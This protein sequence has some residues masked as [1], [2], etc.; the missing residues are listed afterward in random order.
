MEST[1]EQTPI[2]IQEEQEKQDVQEKQEEIVPYEFTQDYLTEQVKN[3][4]PNERDLFIKN[5]KVGDYQRLV[6]GAPLEM[7]ERELENW[8]KLEDYIS[9]NNLDPLPEYY[10]DNQRIGFRILQGTGWKTDVAYTA[11][12]EHWKWRQ[13]TFPLD[14]NKFRDILDSGAV[15]CIGRA[16]EGLQPIIIINVKRFCA[17]N[18][19]IEEQ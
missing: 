11:I 18:K 6:W 17:L 7:R 3:Y 1:T 2:Q 14:I 16:K 19:T 5:E 15:Y 13:E 9:E 12:I 8:K 10:N 4:E